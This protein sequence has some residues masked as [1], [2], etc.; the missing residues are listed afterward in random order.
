MPPS[1]PQPNIPSQWTTEGFMQVYE[2]V[3]RNDPEITY[4]GAYHETE[5]IHTNLFGKP[6]YSSYD[7][8]RQTRKNYV[9]KKN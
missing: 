8:F 4:F 7:S 3:Y 1:T 5:K 6:R 9:T 2:E